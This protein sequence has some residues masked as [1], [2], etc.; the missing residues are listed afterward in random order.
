MSPDA[1]MLNP[2]E[3]KFSQY[4]AIMDTFFERNEVII[5]ILPDGFIRT[6]EPSCMDFQVTS[7]TQYKEYLDQELAY[8]TEHD[9]KKILA[10]YSKVSSISSA[11]SS[12]NSAL[13]YY[14]S[15][16]NS[17]SGGDSQMKS[18]LNAISSGTV[19]SKTMLA[20]FL[21]RNI[22]KGSEFFKGL[23]HGLSTSKNASFTATV[24]VVE[25]FAAAL[26]YRSFAESV[27]STFPDMQQNVDVSLSTVMDKLSQLNQDYV[28]AFHEQEQRLASITEQTNA[29]LKTMS[30]ES[31]KYFAE[32]NKMCDELEE[33][34]TE[35]LRL[36]APAEY[37][38]ELEKEYARKGGWWL[39]ASVCFATLVVVALIAVLAFL[40]NIFSED[41]HWFDIF[42]NSAI[43]T[44]VASVAI[45]ILHLFVKLA[46]SSIHLSRDAKERN[47][48][49]Y[50]YL[51]LIEGKAV[52]EKERAIVLNSLF[53]RSDTGLLKGDS[54]P[55]MSATLS[56]LV[57]KIQQ[58]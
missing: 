23:K 1:V 38:Q 55:T 24:G 18:S 39:F 25:G 3:Q 12:F 8:W 31:N 56:D 57:D 53:S 16:P 34:Y 28:R 15:N 58:K 20:S 41:A 5:K 21:L 30:E 49:T 22:E 40:P 10:D 33:L 54:A 51:A 17:S 11:I 26:E 7:A 50:F 35:K 4:P 36:K 13:S 19:C 27:Q 32:R 45:Y 48:L 2:Q 46:T 52:T 9:P 44:V 6:A 47:K 42:K 29:H 37:W 14:K 43:V